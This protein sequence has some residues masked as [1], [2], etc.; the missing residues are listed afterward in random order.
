MIKKFLL[1][2]KG[3]LNWN[4]IMKLLCMPLC[5]LYGKDLGCD[6]LVGIVIG[7]FLT[8]I[9]QDIQK[10]GV[11]RLLFFPE[12]LEVR[13]VFEYI[14]NGDLDA[15]KLNQKGMPPSYLLKMR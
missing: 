9:I 13:R 11:S 2:C 14:V 15:L 10:Y 12:V 8:L 5:F 4:N 1:W 6:I 3:H 7:M